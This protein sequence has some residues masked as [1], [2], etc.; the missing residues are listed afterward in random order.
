METLAILHHKLDVLP[1]SLWREANLFIDFL[2]EKSEQSSQKAQ[3]MFG[4]ARGKIHMSKD[5]DAPVADF[6]DYM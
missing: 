1:P 6:K 5:F 3:R 2:V 4:S